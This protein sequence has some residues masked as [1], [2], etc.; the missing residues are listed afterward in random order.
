MVGQIFKLASRNLWRNKRRTAITAASIMFAVFFSVIISSIQEGTWDHMVDSVVHYHFGYAQIHHRGYWDDKSIDNSFDPQPVMLALEGADHLRRLV[1]RLESFALASTGNRTIGTLV[2]GID[3]EKENTLS[4]PGQRIVAGAYFAHDDRGVLVAEGLAEYLRLKVG[5]TLI[6]ISQGY[7]GV[8]AAGKFPVRGLVYFGSPELNKQL[9]YLS[10]E[11]AGRF[12]GAEGLVTA[13][14]VDPARPDR[15]A[16]A[17]QTLDLAL[18]RQIYDLMD[19]KEMMPDLIQA[20]EL[21]TAGAVVI[22]FILYILVG[23]G[24]FGT[25]LMMLKERQYEFGILKAIGMRSRWINLMV[26]VETVLMGLLGC[27]AGIALAF[28]ITYYFYLN[29]I[30]LTGKMAEAYEVFGVEA[31]LPAAVDP[32]IYFNQALVIFFMVSLLALYA[33]I[34]IASLRPVKAMRS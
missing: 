16:L 29:P 10:L 11:E 4:S 6:L 15:L 8:N 1:P 25:I 22:L 7:R 21:D 5:D 28:P 26:W 31:L 23:F 17:M 14:V 27:L 30:R 2:I 18:D 24:I 33:F 20:R 12:Y 19:Y 13:L 34:Q 32:K 3:P 9:V